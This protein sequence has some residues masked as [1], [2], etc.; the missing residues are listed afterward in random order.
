MSQLN[1]YFALQV[2]VDTD[3]FSNLSQTN[4]K[5]Q[6]IEKAHMRMLTLF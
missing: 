1:F 4:K 5:C 6:P 2:K 3:P